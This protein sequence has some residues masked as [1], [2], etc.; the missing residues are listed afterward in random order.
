[1][2]ASIADKQAVEQLKKVEKE[3]S[4][5]PAATFCRNRLCHASAGF[6]SLIDALCSD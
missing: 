2:A 4:S 3:G 1:M 5:P 6:P